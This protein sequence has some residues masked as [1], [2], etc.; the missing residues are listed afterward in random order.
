MIC[1]NQ[2]LC[3]WLVIG[4][5]VQN[6]KDGTHGGYRLFFGWTRPISRFLYLIG[7]EISR[8]GLL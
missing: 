2:A 8:P 5:N 6:E 7:L 1:L 4:F 3:Y